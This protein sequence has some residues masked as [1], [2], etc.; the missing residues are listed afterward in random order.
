MLLK[1][2]KEQDIRRIY[3]SRMPNDFA[4]DEIKPLERI[5]KLHEEGKYF[6]YGAYDGNIFAGYCFL[7]AS[8]Y[9][10][11][12]LLDYF[13]VSNDMRGKGYGGRCLALLKAEIE[14]NGLGTLILEVENPRFGRDEE[15]KKLRRRRISFYIK[16]GMTLTHLRIFLYNVEYLVMTGQ[17][18]EMLETAEQLY[19]TYQVLLKPDKLNTR[20]RISANIRCFAL[21][22]DRTTLNEEGKLSARTKNA[23]TEALNMG[24]SVIVASGRA[25]DTLPKDVT[26]IPGLEYAVSSNGA[27][28]WQKDECIRRRILKEESVLTLIEEYKKAR[29]EFILTME[30][31][32]QGKAF[33]ERAYFEEPE[34]FGSE[35][36]V[37][38]VQSTRAVTEDIVKF[39]KDHK[40]ELENIDFIS[41][42]KDNREKFWQRLSL[43]MPDISLTSSAEHLIEISDKDVSKGESLKW[44]LERL[45]IEPEECAAFGDGDNDVSML[46]YAGIGIAVENASYLAKKSADYVT[47][48]HFQD[49]VAV[50]MEEILQKRMENI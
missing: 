38:Y 22:M 49:G 21:D 32:Y 35:K 45:Q 44:L 50:V 6:C 13:A 20:L 31:F 7:A 39:A 16:N 1:Q 33:C 9:R 30:V 10:D 27:S 47:K 34:C 5:L 2:L 24:F 11:A 4:K 41:P 46:Q 3:E 36:A 17:K 14:R 48:P 18:Q 25:Y 28:V 26:S 15:E 29:K 19:H 43:Q 12:V 40:A 37:K 42:D 8:R 23:I